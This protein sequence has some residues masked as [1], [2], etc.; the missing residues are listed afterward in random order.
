MRKCIKCG[1]KSVGR[2]R[3]RWGVFSL[4]KFKWISRH[5]VWLSLF[6]L[7]WGSRDKRG[8]I[9]IASLSLSLPN[10]HYVNTL[11]EHIST[12]A[13]ATAAKASLPCRCAPVRDERTHSHS[14]V[15]CRTM[16]EH[17][18]F[19]FT[20]QNIWKLDSAG[21]TDCSSS[22]NKLMAEQSH[23]DVEVERCWYLLGCHVY[24]WTRAYTCKQ[25]AM[26]QA[27]GLR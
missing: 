8:N 9:I 16:Q 19:T 3:Q 21:W 20:L 13:C 10:S 6:R 11:R 24:H 27:S 2:D 15:G 22:Q 17:L 5:A 18:P 14:E 4:L 26:W 12:M 25:A 23:A 1:R 7:N